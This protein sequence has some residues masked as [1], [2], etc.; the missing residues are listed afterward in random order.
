MPAKTAKQRRAMAAAAAG[1]STIGIP[2]SVGREFMKYLEFGGK[3]KRITTKRKAGST[4]PGGSRPARAGIPE[5]KTVMKPTP[6]KM[7]AYA[8]GMRQHILNSG[9]KKKSYSTGGTSGGGSVG[10]M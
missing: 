10:S 7:K 3:P 4:G 5:H 2:Q 8:T 1:N 9:S 6:A